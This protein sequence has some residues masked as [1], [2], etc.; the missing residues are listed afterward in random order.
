MAFERVHIADTIGRRKWL[1]IE[2][3][4]TDRLAWKTHNAMLYEEV[5]L[6]LDS[7]HDLSTNL[8]RNTVVIDK[9]LR[10]WLVLWRVVIF[11]KHVKLQCYTLFSYS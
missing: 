8:S 7:S 10:Q 1:A 9:E 2:N 3:K 5:V 4:L 6:V 11:Q